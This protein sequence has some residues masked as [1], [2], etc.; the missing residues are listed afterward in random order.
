MVSFY[1]IMT[2]GVFQ[3]PQDLKGWGP[4]PCPARLHS[5]RHFS[6]TFRMLQSLESWQ[7]LPDPGSFSKI[8]KAELPVPPL[9]TVAR[10][11]SLGHISDTCRKLQSVEGT[12]AALA[13]SW[14]LLQGLQGWA[15]C[16]CPVNSCKAWNPGRPCLI[17]EAPLRPSRVSYLPQL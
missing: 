6:D 8:C 11:H 3:H 7:P 10:L 15:T 13:W 16:L 4:C 17:L 5:L 1:F 9:S 2:F 14:K 12:M